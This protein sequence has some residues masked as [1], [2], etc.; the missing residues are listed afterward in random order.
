MAGERVV[1]G[2]FAF[3]F[4][5]ADRKERIEMIAVVALATPMEL[6]FSKCGLSTNTNVISCRCS[7]LP[8][9][10]SSS[11]WAAEQR[12]DA[13]RDGT[14]SPASL[15]PAGGL[16]CMD[17]RRHLWRGHVTPGAGLHEVGP[18]ASFVRRHGLGCLGHGTLGHLPRKLDVGE[19]SAVDKPHRLESTSLGGC[20][21]LFWRPFG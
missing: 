19:R 8:A 5:I 7:Y 16:W 4:K 14:A 3:I 6:F 1:L 17:R 11:I 2:R 9:I 13:N 12:T 10:T 20:L 21:L 15:C 18:S